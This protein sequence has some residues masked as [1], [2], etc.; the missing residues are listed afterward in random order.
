MLVSHVRHL[1]TSFLQFLFHSGSL[2][3]LGSDATLSCLL[4]LTQSRRFNVQ[5]LSQIMDLLRTTF[6]SIKLRLTDY[7]RN[8][9]VRINLKYSRWALFDSHSLF[10]ELYLWWETHT[11]RR[12][13]LLTRC[14]S[15]TPTGR[16]ERDPGWI[17]V[18]SSAT[19][20][21]VV[22]LGD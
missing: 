22:P 17:E 14:S 20:I 13:L 8:Y 19:Q 6:E 3:L 4:C 16:F 21:R 12:R 11:A 10:R 18:G 15:R 9:Q 7:C 5:L 1:R 2:T